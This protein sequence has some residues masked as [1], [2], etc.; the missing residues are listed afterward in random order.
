MLYKIGHAILLTLLLV[1]I[2]GPVQAASWSSTRDAAMMLRERGNPLEA[3]KMIMQARPSAG[4]DYVD[5]Q[6]TAGF[7]ALR[8]LNRPDI[9][10]E[11]F[12][13][14][15]GSVSQTA[16]S[17]QSNRRSQAGYWLGRTLQA[18]GKNNE[19][20]AMYAAAAAYRDTFYGQMSASMLGLSNNAQ[21]FQPYRTYY[22]DMEIFWHD[23]R[24]QKELVLAIIK[25]ESS[26]QQQAVSS[27]GAKGLMQIMDGTALR[28]GQLAGV[29]IDLRQ[30]AN[31]G[32][33]NVAVGSKIVGDLLQ[34]YNGN[35]LLM[36]ASYNAGAG[37]ADEWVSRFGD[38]RSGAIDPVDWIELITFR[39]TRDY[40]KK[41]IS[42]YITYM[43]LAR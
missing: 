5:Q 24:V 4:R 10:L 30:V 8:F 23:P 22:P 1:A 27:A 2:A 37:K 41:I 34:R 25:G 43:G 18:Q 20:N 19:A 9:A 29:N 7:L 6:F 15:A 32:H 38:P 42:N 28:T 17:D 36:A 11:H 35:I 13:E 40:V 16:K 21:I 33:Y 26:F 14:M 3:Y 12:K 31:N 39:E